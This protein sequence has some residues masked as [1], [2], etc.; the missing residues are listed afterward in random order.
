MPIIAEYISH[1]HRAATSGDYY[2]MTIKDKESLSSAV[3]AAMQVLIFV[4]W[5]ERPISFA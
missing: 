5:R 1:R 2:H 4:K 3:L